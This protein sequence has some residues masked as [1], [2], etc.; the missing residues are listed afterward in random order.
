MILCCHDS[1]NRHL[2]L[3]QHHIY[4]ILEDRPANHVRYWALPHRANAIC[5]TQ[6]YGDAICSFVAFHGRARVF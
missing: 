5:H 1:H 2:T 6:G 4:A 3:Q